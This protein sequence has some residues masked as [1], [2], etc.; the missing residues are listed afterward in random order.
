[1][2]KLDW[3]NNRADY[4]ELS[5]VEFMFYCTGYNERLDGRK[6]IQSLCGNKPYVDGFVK[7][8]CDI[9]AQNG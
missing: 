8:D 1:M 3:H 2:N 9:S 7:A 4:P 5:D 6:L